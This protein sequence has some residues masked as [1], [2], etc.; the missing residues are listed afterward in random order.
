MTPP[1][2]L[3]GELRL[4]SAFL[5]RGDME[6]IERQLQSY[7]LLPV[8]AKDRRWRMD[9]DA[10]GGYLLQYTFVLPEAP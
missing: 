5:Q 4:P 8:Q 6:E 7:G 3:Q 9:P 10:P 2:T 1:V